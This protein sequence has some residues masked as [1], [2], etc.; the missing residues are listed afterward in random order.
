MHSWLQLEFI[1]MLWFQLLL[2]TII[3]GLKVFF[4]QTSFIKEGNWRAN[5]TK[6]DYLAPR[7]TELA[8]L[9]LLNTAH[10]FSWPTRDI[11]VKRHWTSV[12]YFFACRYSSLHKHLFFALR[13]RHGPRKCP[14]LVCSP[15]TPAFPNSLHYSFFEG[16][17]S[18]RA[19]REM[20]NV[21]ISR[22]QAWH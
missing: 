16:R 9:E 20:K 8:Y 5:E 19:L 2:H 11:T 22:S 4:A 14:P 21:P 18:I 7:Q 6:I 12:P 15:P 10:S 3:Q 1:K 17:A 13:T